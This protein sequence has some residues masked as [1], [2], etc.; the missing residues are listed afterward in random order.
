VKTC[1]HCTRAVPVVEL[2][3]CPE[4]GGRMCEPA[5]GAPVEP[6]GAPGRRAKG[7]ERRL[8]AATEP[9]QAS[10]SPRVER[11]WLPGRLPGLND[12]L[13]TSVGARIRHQ[14]GPKA[15][16]SLLVAVQRI[17]PFER[18]VRLSFEWHEPNMRRDPDGF[19]AGGAKVAIDALVSAG[20][21][22][23]DGWRYIAALTHTWRVAKEPGVWVTLE[24]VE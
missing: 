6:R 18:P 3:H 12:L 7:A 22:K 21:L 15:A 4:R 11:F 2:S 9:E 19:C 13:F 24:E 16:V 5:P 20:T 10:A 23:G 17:K 14:K 8:G 1:R